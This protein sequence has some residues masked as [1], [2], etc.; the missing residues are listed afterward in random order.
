MM[1]NKLKF[2][3]KF[4][5]TTFS[6]TGPNNLIPISSGLISLPKTMMSF[7]RTQATSPIEFLNSSLLTTIRKLPH[8]MRLILKRLI[9]HLLKKPKRS[10]TTILSL[11]KKLI[12]NTA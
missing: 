6:L 4:G 2:P 10:L 7:S 12:L 9:L 5:G 11:L 3:S 8:L 1:L